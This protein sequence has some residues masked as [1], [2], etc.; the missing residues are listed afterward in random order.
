MKKVIL[1]TMFLT[2]GSLSVN[3]QGIKFGVKADQFRQREIGRF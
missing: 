1:L 2:L 3:A